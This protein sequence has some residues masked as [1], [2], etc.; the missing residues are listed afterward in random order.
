MAIDLIKVIEVYFKKRKV[1]NRD[2]YEF[3]KDVFSEIDIQ[4]NG[5]KKRRWSAMEED[6]IRD[7]WYEYDV[8]KIAKFLNRD[9]DSV[10]L[11]AK[12]CFGKGSEKDGK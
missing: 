10:E 4:D 6:Y 8:D 7:H 1:L 9:V 2:T 11:K 12:E 5:T 3:W